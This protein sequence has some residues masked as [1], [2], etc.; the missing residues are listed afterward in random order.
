VDRRLINILQ[1]YIAAYKPDEWFFEGDIPGKHLTERTVQKVFESFRKKAG[2][3]KDVF[4]R[5]V[6][7]AD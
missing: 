3:M 6:H 7:G 1:E 4:G 2:I 5:T